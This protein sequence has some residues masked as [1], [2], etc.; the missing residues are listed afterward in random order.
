ME[1]RANGRGLSERS[2][3]TGSVIRHFCQPLPTVDATLHGVASACE[4]KK[5][6]LVNLY[7]E[8]RIL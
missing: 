6:S 2:V 8:Y 7:V 5:H 4:A 3:L 1:R